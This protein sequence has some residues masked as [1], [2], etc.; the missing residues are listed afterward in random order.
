[1]FSNRPKC[2]CGNDA[3][4]IIHGEYLCGDCA[5]RLNNIQKEQFK[6]NLKL[7]NENGFKKSIGE[8]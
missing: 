8:Q 7:I 5:V 1:M 2:I 3:L 4:I 6:I